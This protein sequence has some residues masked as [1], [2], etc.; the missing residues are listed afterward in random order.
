MNRK[1]A[2]I[3]CLCSCG[4]VLTAIVAYTLLNAGTTLY[5]ADV[6]N[7]YPHDVHAFTQGL[8]FYDGF[9]YES[10]GLY[11]N[12]SLRCV[13]LETGQVLKIYHLPGEFFAEGI[14]IF[15]DKIIQL[16]WREH[17][18]FVYNRS[19]FELID[20]FSYSTEGWGITSDGQRLIMSDGS[21]KLYFL[22]PQTFEKIGEVEVLDNG[23]PISKLNELEYVNGYVYAN[24]WYETKIAIIDVNRGKVTAWINCSDVKATYCGN[25]LN[26]IAYDTEN[27]RLFITGKFWNQLFEVKLV[28]V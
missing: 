19:S 2:L 24:V 28:K 27:N 7:S 16:T 10:T 14:T 6:V 5:Y 15:D 4:L 23:K 11:G 8:V 26:G 9:L 12:S 13:D 20:E 21:A 3:I 1:F 18:G 22:D 25:V 17:K